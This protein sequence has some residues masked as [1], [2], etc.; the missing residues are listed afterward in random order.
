MLEEKS[1]HPNFFQLVKSKPKCF[2][3]FLTLIQRHNENGIVMMMSRMDNA[4]NT[5]AVNPGPSG[6]SNNEKMK[7]LFK[8]IN[9]HQPLYLRS[10]PRFVTF[11][12]TCNGS[13]INMEMIFGKGV[14]H[15]LVSGRDFR[16]IFNGLVKSIILLARQSFGTVFEI[17]TDRCMLLSV[18][19]SLYVCMKV[20][21]E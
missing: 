13:R 16:A 2:T 12:A 21:N 11:I 3:G 17:V 1:F 20:R 9:E 6:S 10:R 19:L 8:S 15:L 18:L 7:T 14:S 4:V 5:N